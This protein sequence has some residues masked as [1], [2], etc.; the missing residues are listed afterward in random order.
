MERG[1]GDIESRLR[2]LDEEGIWAEVIYHSIG[3]W[4]SMIKDPKL[5]QAATRARTSGRRPR[6]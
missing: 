3:L 6:S 4:E 2:D 1:A 5:L